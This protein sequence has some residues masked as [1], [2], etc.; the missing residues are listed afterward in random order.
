LLLL[1]SAD[2]VARLA[3]LGGALTGYGLYKLQLQGTDLS[4][5]VRLVERLWSEPPSRKKGKRRGTMSDA[6]IIEERDDVDI[7]K[8]IDELLDKVA[9]NGYDGLSKE[10]KRRLFEASQ[11][12]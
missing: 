9:K 12:K 5:W 11:R 1:G 7:R 3:H 2:G 8:E 6:T 4:G 10:E